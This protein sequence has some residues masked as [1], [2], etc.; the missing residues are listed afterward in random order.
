MCRE[1]LPLRAILMEILKYDLIANH[2][3]N[4]TLQDKF[5]LQSPTLKCVRNSKLPPSI[6]YEDNA[7][8][9]ILATEPDQN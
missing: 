2:D 6:I 3:K 1:L 8:C 4:A 9:I 5:M 7:G